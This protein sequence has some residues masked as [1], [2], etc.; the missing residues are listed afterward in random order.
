MSREQVVATVIGD[1]VGSRSAGSRSALHARPGLRHTRTAY[2]RGEVVDGPADGPVN[3]ALLLSDQILGSLS[4]RSV[5]VLPALLGGMTR[6]EIAEAEGISAS[7]VSQ[8]VRNDGLGALV[9]AEEM[10][11]TVT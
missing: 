10:L 7:A 8:R 11:R 3:A 5:G 9:A 4:E 2:S 1:K 6:R